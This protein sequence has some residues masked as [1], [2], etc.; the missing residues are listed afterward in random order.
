MAALRKEL[1]E[2]A[3]RAAGDE[4]EECIN[5]YED[6]DGTWCEEE[7]QPGS[8]WRRLEPGE[9]GYPGKEYWREEAR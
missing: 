1:G 4:E 7:A 3:K 9:D 2:L 6:D 5:P 8:W